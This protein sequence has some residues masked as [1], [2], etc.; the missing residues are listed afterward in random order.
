MVFDC[1]NS[2][3]PKCVFGEFF[4][5][6]V[7]G[8]STPLN[9]FKNWEELA[10]YR[11]GKHSPENRAEIHQKYTK[12]EIWGIFG[13]FLP[14][15]ASGAIFLFSRGPTFS[16]FKNLW[17]YCNRT[18]DWC[19]SC[20]EATTVPVAAVAVFLAVSCSQDRILSGIRYYPPPPSKNITGSFFLFVEL[21]LSG[22]TGKIGNMVTGNNF[23]GIN[24]IELPESL[25]GSEAM[26]LGDEQGLPEILV[27]RL[28][29][30]NSGR[31]NLEQLPE[32]SVIGNLWLPEKMLDELIW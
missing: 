7:T 10:P 6:T 30:R 21:I 5:V 32:K 2:V 18:N 28:P 1:L 3:F 31:I 22:I 12:N 23:W 4:S 26:W 25:A 11:I 8:N 9:S 15:F 19:R 29:E 24:S 17:T 14:F 13:V 20:L 16:Q 27:T